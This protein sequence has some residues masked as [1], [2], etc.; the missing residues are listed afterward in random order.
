MP[1]RVGDTL[2]AFTVERLLGRGA[3]GEVFLVRGQLHYAMKVIPCDLGPN[4]E[5]PT[6]PSHFRERAQVADPT[7]QAALAEASLLQELRYP[8]IVSC[9]EILFDI[10]RSVVCLVLEYMDGGDLHGLIE[11]HRRENDPFDGH[12]PRRVLAAVGGALQYIHEMGILHRD[13][14]PANVLLSRR[15]CRI[16]LADFGIAKLVEAA[17]LK[18]HT[19]V[20]TP[21]YFSPELV[22]GE[23]YGPP[24]D[25]WALGAVLYEIVA[26][27]RPF[28][29]SNQLALVRKIC[30]E[31]PTALPAE[32]ADDISAAVDGLLQKDVRKRMSMAEVLS[33]SSPVAAL[34][35]PSF[36]ANEVPTEEECYAEDA[37]APDC[38]GGDTFESDSD[39]WHDADLV[40]SWRASNAAG[41]AR[42][43]LGADEDDP[44]E[45]RCALQALQISPHSWDFQP[46][47]WNGGVCRIQTTRI[48]CRRA[49]KPQLIR[50]M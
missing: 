50:Q 30:E 23:E 33:I 43:A 10:E 34:V 35:A 8:H 41:L 20:G 40:T 13:V 46:F 21:Y 19:L 29:A 22:S 15:S 36:Q 47:G 31:T 2:G 26:L 9:E 32:T 49:T 42:A 3:Y 6:K 28:E 11:Q 4:K 18:A 1:Y 16:K 24:A 48:L 12:F 14:K 44:E 17:T 27:R 39:S 38:D 37:S 25:C 7:L 45:L 5:I